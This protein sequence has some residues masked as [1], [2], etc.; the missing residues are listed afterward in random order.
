MPEGWKRVLNREEDTKDWRIELIDNK[1]RIRMYIQ[2][3]P[4]IKA[5][6]EFVNRFQIIY[7]YEPTDAEQ[8]IIAIVFDNQTRENI[9][10]VKATSTPSKTNLEAHEMADEWMDQNYP[11]DSPAAYWD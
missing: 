6:A 3:E 11:C 5:Y 9:Y 4:S 8:D 1:R 2:F 10:E 7:K